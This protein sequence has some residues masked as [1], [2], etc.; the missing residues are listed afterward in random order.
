[1]E[2]ATGFSTHQAAEWRQWKG[3]KTLRAQGS[4]P[5][6]VGMNWLLRRL[7]TPILV[8]SV[9]STALL[10]IWDT[11]VDKRWALNI[12]DL[13]NVWPF[14][15][16]FQAVGLTLL[17]PLGLY[18]VKRST[19]PAQ[20]SLVLAIAGSAIGA[21]LMLPISVGGIGLPSLPMACGALGALVWS[22][23]NR[24]PAGC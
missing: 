18:L 23:F 21:L 6:L 9:A 15:L 13:V 4:P 3:K 1:M 8:G 11:P 5:T 2:V 20:S 7:L 24:G 16:L 17:L 22:G 14:V 19:P 12:V 10:F